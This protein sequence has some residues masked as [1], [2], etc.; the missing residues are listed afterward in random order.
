MPETVPSPGVSTPGSGTASSVP[1]TT[2]PKAASTTIPGSLNS[3]GWTLIDSQTFTGSRVNEAVWGIY[4]GAGTDGVGVR[5]RSAVNVANGELTITGSGQ[6]V[7]GLAQTKTVRTYGRWVI[8][9][10]LD[11]GKGYGSAILLWP[12]SEHWPEDGEID[13][14]ETVDGNRAHA[15]S[16][17][18]Y[19]DDNQQQAHDVAGDFSQWHTYAVDWLPNHI[20]FYVDGRAHFTVTDPAAIPR[21][22]MFLA[23]QLDT[24]VCGSNWIGCPDVSTPPAVSL[25]VSSVQVYAPN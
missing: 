19:G 6:T 14:A 18:H 3:E 2:Q 8:R 21:N 5:R 9:A 7:G 11:K 20:T 10:K 15:S 4:E 16:T 1:A 13:I 17:V 12:A 22:R 24:G 23:L 25:H